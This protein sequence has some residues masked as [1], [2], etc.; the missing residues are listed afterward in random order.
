MAEEC[1]D[2]I[3][4]RS[5]S[6]VAVSFFDEDSNAVTPDAAIYRIDSPAERTN[7]LPAT[8]F[9]SLSTS[10]DLEITSDENRIL[11]ERHSSEIRELTVEFDY[12]AVSGPKHGTAKY[13]YRVLNLYGVV[14]IPSASVSPSASASPSV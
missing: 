8:A 10:V 13:R 5:S 9:P 1:L 6:T 3:T 12:T 2:E 14:T 7:I 11:R 4:E